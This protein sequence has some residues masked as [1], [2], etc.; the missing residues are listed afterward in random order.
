MKQVIDNFSEQATLYAKFRPVYPKQLFDFLYEHVSNFDSALDSGCG[1]GQVAAELAQKFKR[2]YATDISLEQLKQ[3]TF[4]NNISYIPCR[5]EQTLLESK[6]IDFFTVAQAIHWFDTDLFYQEVIRL[7]KPNALIAVWGY[8]LLKINPLI[9]KCIE[10]FYHNIVG[11]YWDKE[12]KS[13]E[14][15]YSN[16][17]FPFQS[18]KTPGFEMQLNW[19]FETLIGYLN[20]WSSVSKYKKINNS[21]PIDLIENE[22]QSAWGNAPFQTV[23]F[24][25]FCKTGKVF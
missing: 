19:N 25:V 16:I 24:P 17:P 4:R 22:L 2:V 10:D 9:D 13:V 7:A 5:S 6:S 12:R 14:T 15:A 11:K 20:S 23:N 18:I 21:N 8:N 3:A 1:N